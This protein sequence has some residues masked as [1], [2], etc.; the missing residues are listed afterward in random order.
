MDFQWYKIKTHIN[1]AKENRHVKVV[2]VHVI[3]KFKRPIPFNVDGLVQGPNSIANV[4]ELCF[5]CTN[6]SIY[7]WW[8]MVWDSHIRAVGIVGGDI[9]INKASINLIVKR[10][11][12]MSYSITD[13][14][15]E[16]KSSLWEIHID[17]LVQDR[18]NS[19]MTVIFLRLLYYQ[20]EL[21]KASVSI[22]FCCAHLLIA[23]Q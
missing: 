13:A 19:S 9:K 18:S 4:L 17:D 8:Q 2:C 21:S 12:K 3:F 11:F 7:T 23:S 10:F 1:V 14:A 16:S 20:L 22:F 15:R 5:S 6:P